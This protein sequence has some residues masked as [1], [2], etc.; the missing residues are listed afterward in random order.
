MNVFYNVNEIKAARQEQRDNPVIYSLLG[1]VIGE[2]DR[3][4]IPR[5]QEPTQDQIYA[6][7]KKL[8]EA[9]K[10]M[11]EMTPE[12]DQEYMYLKDFIKKQLSEADI[13]FEIEDLMLSKNCNI[14]MIMKH[15][16]EWYPGQYDGK[17]VNAIAREFI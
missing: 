6:V 12:A 2:L 14:G 9:A 16:K 7:I 3:L 10:E 4:P 5:G 8:Y 15:F 1:V 13:R 11:R 17:M